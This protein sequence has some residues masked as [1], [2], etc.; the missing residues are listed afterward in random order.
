MLGLWAC[1]DG[2][3]GPGGAPARLEVVAGGEQT[4]TVGQVLGDPIVARVTDD[5][6]RGVA[7]VMVTFVAPDGS[8]VFTPQ[9]RSTDE[10][11]LAQVA[12]T[13]GPRAGTL[14]ATVTIEGLAPEPLSAVAVARAAARLAFDAIPEGASGGLAFDPPVAVVVEDEFGN[15]VP[16]SSAEILLRLNQGTL[17]GATSVRAVNGRATFPGLHIDQPGTGYVLTASAEGLSPAESAPFPVATGAVAQIQVAEGDGQEAAAGSPVAIAPTVVVR[18]ADGNPIAG[19]GVRFTVTGGGGTVSPA[20]VITGAD[21]RAA[22]AAWTLGTTVGENTLRASPAALPGA[23]VEFTAGATA[24]P[25]DPSR[26]SVTATPETIITG[27]TSVIEVTALDA[28]GNPV[29]G[30]RGRAHRRR[31]RQ[32]AGPAARHRRERTG[33]RELPFGERRHQDGLGGGR[34]R[35]AGPAGDHRRGAASRARFGAGDPGRILAAGGPDRS[36]HRDR[37]RRSGPADRGGGGRLEQRRPAGGQRRRRRR[38]HRPK[39]RQR[40]DHRDERWEERERPGLG[41]SR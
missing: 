39:H 36:A 30:A 25:V 2:P 35:G 20:T 32:H 19:A 40:D 7:G 1:G 11:G 34:R 33:E 10:R 14:S 31:L 28:F 38:G 3:Q 24:G 21:G 17:V 15:P 13:L 41:E 18:D 22:V 16:G 9:I 37:A 27:A 4:G 5:A 29:P 6:G 8:G 26:S 12:W 23:S